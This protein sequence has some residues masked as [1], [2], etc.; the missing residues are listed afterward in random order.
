MKTG[1][2]LEWLSS[3]GISE[4]RTCLYGNWSQESQVGMWG[5]WGR[6]GRKFSKIWRWRESHCKEQGLSFSAD[7]L[8]NH[9]A[10][11]PSRG[12]CKGIHLLL[13][14]TFL[15]EHLVWFFFFYVSLT[16]E[17]GFL[18]LILLV[19]RSH[20]MGIH[21]TRNVL[22]QQLETIC[23]HRGWHIHQLTLLLHQLRD[24]TWGH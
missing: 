21:R 10:P 15:W 4:I 23:Q 17:F 19:I 24:I 11:D 1:G 13:R 5:K 7:P 6:E 22:V 9:M 2:C 16:M 14:V 20:F 3:T 18:F 12:V 8:R